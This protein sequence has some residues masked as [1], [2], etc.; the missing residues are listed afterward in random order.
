M[1]LRASFHEKGQ[2]ESRT[3]Q[4]LHPAM[5]GLWHPMPEGLLQG[6]EYTDHLMSWGPQFPSSTLQLSVMFMNHI[7][8]MPRKSQPCRLEPFSCPWGHRMEAHNMQCDLRDH[9]IQ[10]SS[11]LSEPLKHSMSQEG[12]RQGEGPQG[13]Y[14][15]GGGSSGMGSWLGA[16]GFTH[17]GVS[18]CYNSVQKTAE[19]QW[20]SFQ[21]IWVEQVMRARLDLDICAA[22]QAWAWDQTGLSFHPSSATSSHWGTLR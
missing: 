5:A 8:A 2:M 18:K 14:R 19:G 21:V 17:L 7:I 11:S 10:P 13:V 15:K 22:G 3:K 20:V 4:G 6:L 1:F 12:P 16:E 9:P